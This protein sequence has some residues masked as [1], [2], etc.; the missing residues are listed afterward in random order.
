MLKRALKIALA[1]LLLAGTLSAAQAQFISPGERSRPRAW[2]TGDCTWNPTLHVILCPK[3]NGVTIGPLATLSSPL[4]TTNGGTGIDAPTAHSLLQAEGTSALGLITAA[5]AGN[6]PIDQGAGSDWLSKALSGDCALAASGAITCTKTS[7]TAFGPLATVASESSNVIYKGN[8]SS[9]PTASALS[10]NGTIVS[11]SES[12]DLTSNALI[13]E[14]ANASSTGTTLNKLAKLTGAPSTALITATTDTNTALGVVVGNAGT[15]GN[16]QIALEGQASCV[17]D[18]ATTAGDY[19]QISSTVAGDCHDAG[20]TYPTS[21]EVLGRVL[22]TNGAGGTYAMLLFGPEIDAAA[23]GGGGL[24]S[25]DIVAGTGI[26]ESGTCNSTSSINCTLSVS[27][28]SLATGSSTGHTLTAPF[29]YFVCTSTCTVTPPVPAAGYQFCVM[30]G[31]NVSTVITLGAIGSSAYYEKTQRTGYGTAGT[32]TL[33]SGGAVGDMVCIV[34]LDSTH[35]LTT[36][37]VGTWTAS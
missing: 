19:V 8:G 7:G 13:S 28:P 6:I 3:V 22:S 35:Y 18:G 5:T 14:I 30:N 21:N 29:G 15:T 9:A 36:T 24:S 34:G 20:A 4:N 27:A 37:F 25:V 17:F 32:G 23:G 33:T 12:I 26:S 1:T 2:M 11:S 31:D 10:D 16:A